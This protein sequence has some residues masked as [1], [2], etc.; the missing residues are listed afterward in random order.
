ME[1]AITTF[2]FLI[3]VP[4]VT[5]FI[6]LRE[7]RPTYEYVKIGFMCL[8]MVLFFVG[9]YSFIAM[10]EISISYTTVTPELVEAVTGVITGIQS[11]TGTGTDAGTG[12]QT[13]TYRTV[14]GSV[15]VNSISSTSEVLKASSDQ[16][17]IVDHSQQQTGS[18][19]ANFHAF[20]TVNKF[21]FFNGDP[22][23]YTRG[24]TAPPELTSYLY[25]LDSDFEVMRIGY[26]DNTGKVGSFYDAFVLSSIYTMFG[27][28]MLLFFVSELFR[29][30]AAKPLN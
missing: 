13:F 2:I 15:V 18:T 1:L 5:L 25:I 23:T 20:D 17:S 7:S 30:P 4:F 9:A 12:T 3:I 22:N 19:T 21:T 28:L 29:M 11:E 24:V 6:A 8:T 16:H 10:D 14:N 27:L 26:L